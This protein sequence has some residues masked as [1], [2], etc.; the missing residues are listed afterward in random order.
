MRTIF[1]V[2]LIAAGLGACNSNSQQ[3]RALVG[4]A[5]GAATGAVIASAAGANTGETLLAAAGGGI[6]GSLLGAGTTPGT[7][8]VDEFGDP[9]P[10]GT[11]YTSNGR[12]II[13]N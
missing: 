2:V 1:A 8:C 12:E 13:C 3:D 7:N 6:V 9:L 4:G 5:G 11:Y 10:P